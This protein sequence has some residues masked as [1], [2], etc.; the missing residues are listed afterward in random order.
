MDKDFLE[1]FNSV[2]RFHFLLWEP[3]QY[4]HLAQSAGAAEYTEYT[5][6]TDYISAKSVL[7]LTLNNLMV[8]FQ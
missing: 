7:D 6:Y 2:L 4:S 8:R 3:L 5:E 1:D